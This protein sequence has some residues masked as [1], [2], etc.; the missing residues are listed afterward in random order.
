MKVSA[1]PCN[2]EGLS[3]SSDCEASRDTWRYEAN[4][5]G[6]SLGRFYISRAFTLL[7]FFPSSI[8]HTRHADKR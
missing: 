5:V 7:Q 3:G 8:K 1:I 4:K 2:D 6:V